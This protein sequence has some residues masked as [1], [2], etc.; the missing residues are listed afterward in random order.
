MI[1]AH[2]APHKTWWM[3]LSLIFQDWVRYDLAQMFSDGRNV[4]VA[5]MP[6]DRFTIN[7][8]VLYRECVL[9]SKSDWVIKTL[10]CVKVLK[11]WELLS[12]FMLFPDSVQI[13]SDTSSNCQKNIYIFFSATQ[14]KD[15]N[16]LW[17]WHLYASPWFG[18]AEVARHV[19]WK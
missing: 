18:Y 11:K 6:W 16:L 4:D 19:S 10:F 9:R 7:S 15:K 8:D 3:R 14:E 2:L 13:T 1:K 12:T 17:M 5:D